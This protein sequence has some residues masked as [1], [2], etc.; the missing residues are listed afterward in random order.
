M[1]NEKKKRTRYVSKKNA[2]KNILVKSAANVVDKSEV[3]EEKEEVEGK[4]EVAEQ[5]VKVLD[6]S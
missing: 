3:V 6:L 1:L 5:E 2:N 4:V